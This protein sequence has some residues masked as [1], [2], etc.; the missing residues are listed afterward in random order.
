MATGTPEAVANRKADFPHWL[1]SSIEVTDPGA[2]MASVADEAD[3]LYAGHEEEAKA[4][5]WVGPPLE[6]KIKIGLDKVSLAGRGGAD[7][8]E[9]R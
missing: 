3:C 2:P 6:C 5:G 1:G 8:Q 4:D 9:Q 7:T